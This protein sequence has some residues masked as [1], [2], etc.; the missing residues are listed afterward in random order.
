MKKI[1]KTI[2][3]V[4]LTGS[5]LFVGNSYYRYTEL[6]NSYP[7]EEI[8]DNLK[9][10]INNYVEYEDI[11]NNLLDATVAIEDRRFFDRYGVDYIALARAM[12]VNLISLD[13]VE[14]G[15]TIEQQFI[16]IYYYNYQSS[17]TRKVVELFFIYD[18]NDC[19]GKEEILEMYLNV[20]NYGDGY[21]G[22]KEAAEGY[23]GCKTSDLNLY[24]SSLIAGIPNA[25]AYLELSNNNIHTYYRQ[26]L[27]LDAMLE[28]GYISEEE[29]TATIELQPE[30]FKNE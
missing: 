20:I 10:N 13:F 14:G 26:I 19:Y 8:K 7:V 24:R 17:F 16:K 5:I 12:L 4:I 3:I 21:T 29:Y 11:S 25:P 30:E 9:A 28:L 2:L 6:K 1:I 15:S 18:L 23:F 22:I 27:I